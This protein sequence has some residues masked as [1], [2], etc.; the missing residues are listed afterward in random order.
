[1]RKKQAVTR[2]DF[3]KGAVAASAV[4]SL[5]PSSVLGANDRVN[6]GVVGIGRKGS[7]HLKGFGGIKNVDVVAVSDPDLTHMDMKDYTGAKHQDFRKLLEMKETGVI[8]D[9]EYKVL[10]QKTIVKY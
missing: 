3:V 2:R 7:V 10:K 6:V 8:N 1:M 9:D 4:Y 5:L